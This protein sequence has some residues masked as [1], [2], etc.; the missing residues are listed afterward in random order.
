VGTQQAKAG[1]NGSGVNRLDTDDILAPYS[2]GQPANFDPV[3]RCRYVACS[4]F[5]RREAHRRSGRP[6]PAAAMK[7][8]RDFRQGMKLDG[9]SL[10]EL[11]EEG[12]P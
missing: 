8:L 1:P 12:R 6:E 5:A 2:H 3:K 11:I 4:P 10:H 9:L 7:A